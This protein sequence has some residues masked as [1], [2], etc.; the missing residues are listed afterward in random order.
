[1]IEEALLGK[2]QFMGRDGFRW[3]IGQVAPRE[4]QSDQINEGDGWAY[5]YKVRIMG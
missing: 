4:A 3:W 2:S 1:M 5:R